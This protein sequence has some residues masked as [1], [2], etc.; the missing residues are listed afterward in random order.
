MSDHPALEGAASYQFDRNDPFDHS[1]PIVLVLPQLM[2]SQAYMRSVR[3]FRVPPSSLAVW[4]LGQNGFLLKD[5]MGSLIG[6]DLYLTNSCANAPNSYTYRLDRQLPVFIEP[7]DLDI[8]FFI[9]THSHLDHTDPQTISRMSKSKETMFLGPFD[10]ARIFAECGVQS[11]ACR[12]LHPGQVV[13]IGS[14]R[15]QATFAFPTDSTD[16][17]H[18]GILLTFATE[19]TFYN[20]GDTAW[21]DR[22]SFLLPREVDICAICING[23]YH[24]LSPEHAALITKAIN[25]R[26]AIPCHYDMMVNNVGSPNMFRAALER[27]GVHDRFHMLDY[28][29]PWLYKKSPFLSD[30]GEP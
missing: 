14:T 15:L 9:A 4:Y 13:E 5:E 3:D 21:S 24:N 25:P 29:A 19:I 26:V 16:L 20:T 10:A 27:E 12:V 11:S 7:E 1:R 28:Y 22:L 2:S 8:D 30:K 23:G 6:I 17:N 18:I